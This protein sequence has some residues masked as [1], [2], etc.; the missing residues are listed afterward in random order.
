MTLAAGDM[1]PEM[2]TTCCQCVDFQWSEGNT[3]LLDLQPKICPAYR[4][5]RDKDGAEFHMLCKLNDAHKGA[6]DISIRIIRSMKT[7]KGIIA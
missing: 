5:C 3:D 1:K 7:F 6:A 2:A 4:K